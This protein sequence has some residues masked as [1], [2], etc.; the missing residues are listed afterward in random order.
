MQ[1]RFATS[2]RV[3]HRSQVMRLPARAGWAPQRSSTSRRSC[4]TVSARS[5]RGWRV[6]RQRRLRSAASLA[7][8]RD[9]WRRTRSHP[10]VAAGR[11]PG[12]RSSSRTTA[13]VSAGGSRRANR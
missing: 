13:R 1:G 4:A 6:G 8:T 2:G 7:A 9:W 3:E 5:L 10:T 12:S 11:S